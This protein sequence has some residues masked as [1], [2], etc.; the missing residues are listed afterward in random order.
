[1]LLKNR[2]TMKK[3]HI[4]LLMLL[5]LVLNATTAIAQSGKDKI[6]MPE[7]PG[8][9]KALHEY[10]LSEL[11]YPLEAMNNNEMGEVIVGFS[12][13]IDGSVSS[14]RVLKS[15]SPSLDKEA[16][17]VVQGMRYWYPAKKN[18]RLVRAEM[19]IPINFKVVYENKY[20]NDDQVGKN[21]KEDDGSRRVLF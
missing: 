9:E 3:F 4:I 10:I 1:M 21:A 18:G 7:Y 2:F 19:S 13:G 15:V 11:I 5:T 16:I 14:V 12:I 8:G 6:V 20:I 17:R